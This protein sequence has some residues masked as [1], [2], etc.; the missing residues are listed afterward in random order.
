MNR[1]NYFGIITCR[2]RSLRQFNAPRS[3]GGNRF[4]IVQNLTKGN[5]ICNRKR[6]FPAIYIIS[7]RLYITNVVGT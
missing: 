2:S 1:Y 5:I 3:I 7:R 6:S 4:G